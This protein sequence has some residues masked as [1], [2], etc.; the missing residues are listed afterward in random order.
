[1]LR[2]IA[3]AGFAR[4]SGCNIG[5]RY[6]TCTASLQPDDVVT[7]LLSAACAGRTESQR[8]MRGT[9]HRPPG[10]A[11]AVRRCVRWQVALAAL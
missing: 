4:L 3:A 9:D 7:Q 1:M 6:D 8:C 5:A 2:L 11:R 10:H